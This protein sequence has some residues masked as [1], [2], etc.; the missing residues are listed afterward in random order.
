MKNTKRVFYGTKQEALKY[1]F[2]YTTVC[3]ASF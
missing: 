2:P 3:M 1:L